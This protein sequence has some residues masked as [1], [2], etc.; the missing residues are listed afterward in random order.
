MRE[1]DERTKEVL[2]RYAVLERRLAR[3]LD[4]RENL[5]CELRTL[6]SSYDRE[7]ARRDIE[8]RSQEARIRELQD[9]LQ[10]ANN[11]VEKANARGTLLMKQVENLQQEIQNKQN[12]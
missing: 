2:E 4:E 1:A 12:A 5:S 7:I 6:Q 11:T 10:N 8:R 9:D 3:A